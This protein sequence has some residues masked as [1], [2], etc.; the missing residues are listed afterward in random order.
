MKRLSQGVVSEVI[1]M[2][3]GTVIVLISWLVV[4]F[5]SAL[6]YRICGLLNFSQAIFESTSGWTTTGLTMFTDVERLPKSIL[7]W[8]SLT[9]YLGGAGFAVIVM[10]TLIGPTG[11]GFYQ[12]EG[13]VDNIMPNIRYSARLIMTYYLLYAVLGTVALM[14]SGLNFF[15]ALNHSMTALATGGF[16]TKSMS[17]AAFNNFVAE[18]ILILLM[19]IGATGFG[20]HHTFWSKDW[21]ALKKNSEPRQM[22]TLIL[23][24]GFCISLAG[25]GKFFPNWSEALR[26]GFFQVV[27]ALTGTGFSTV[28][29]KAWLFFPTGLFVLI[30]LMLMGGCMDSTSGGIKQYR[31]TVLL[32]TLRFSIKKFLLP[33]NS[34]VYVEIWKGSVKRYLDLQLVKEAFMI[35][36][37]Y[38]LSY[39]VGTFV[40]TLIGYDLGQAMFE[41]ASALAGVGLSCGVTSPNMPL[42]AMWTLTLGMFMGRLEF[43]VVIYAFAKIF[44][45]LLGPL[46][47]KT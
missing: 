10:S 40:L 32:K 29:L 26:H 20:I 36:S 2:K 33:K 34:V 18:L 19:F 45:D 41:F 9:Q 42:G 25:V 28:D 22:I 17:V 4:I 8:R 12:A 43:F 23:L 46:R 21:Y 35:G 39:I 16:S 1:T 30:I 7:F 38:I 14:F 47:K 24:G 37:A 44:S 11:L 15:D 6:P 3:E 5:I 31:I 27:S 13:H